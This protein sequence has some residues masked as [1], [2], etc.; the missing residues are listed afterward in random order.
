MSDALQEWNAAG[1]RVRLF[2]AKPR[3]VLRKDVPVRTQEWTKP[4][5]NIT[6]LL[7]PSIDDPDAVFELIGVLQE[8][9]LAL[10]RQLADFSSGV[11]DLG[12]P[13]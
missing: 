10:D 7:P 5:L 11:L 3:I 1:V 12:S 9:G 2:P 6:V 8:A 4:H 13:S